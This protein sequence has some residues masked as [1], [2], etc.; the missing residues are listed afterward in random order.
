[1]YHPIV[2]KDTVDGKYLLERVRDSVWKEAHCAIVIMSPDD[3]TKQ[4]QFRAR[5]NVV[6][7]LG[8]CLGAFD[9]IEKRYWYNA[10]IILKEKSVETFS[11]LGGIQ[12]IEYQQNLNGINLSMLTETLAAT[13][14]KARKYYEEL[15]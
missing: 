1:G 12:F 8:Y 5:Q 6:F 4:K 13:F 10:V 9:S 2:L 11:D 7:E 15:K 14:N 3:M